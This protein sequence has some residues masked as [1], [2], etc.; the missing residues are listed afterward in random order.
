L[1]QS[2]STNSEARGWLTRR[3]ASTLPFVDN[4]KGGVS[5]FAYQGTNSH[6]T[7]GA[8][9]HCHALVERPQRFWDHRKF[10]FQV[11]NYLSRN[12]Q[13]Q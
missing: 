7:V 12:I 4:S 6:V 5:S 11:H 1:L 13:V 2:Y 10:W 9:Q 3:A 8:M